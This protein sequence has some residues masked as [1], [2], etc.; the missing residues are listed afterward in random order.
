MGRTLYQSTE[1]FLTLQAALQGPIPPQDGR[2]AHQFSRDF[3]AQ[4][5]QGPFPGPG[6]ITLVL[7]T[8]TF[9][10]FFA[11]GP[12]DDGQVSIV[13]S[14]VMELPL[15][16][17]LDGG[18]IQQVGPPDDFAD[19]LV[20]VVHH[21]GQQIG[22]RAIGALQ[23]RGQVGVRGLLDPLISILPVGQAVFRNCQTNGA[24]LRG[25]VM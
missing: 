2:A 20:G 4:V 5:T 15:Q 24:R 25:R 13:G 8:A 22:V 11:I 3:P 10:E 7:V 9:R 1:H 18:E 17:Q 14:G 21:I 19:T 23:D 6:G 16:E 12:E